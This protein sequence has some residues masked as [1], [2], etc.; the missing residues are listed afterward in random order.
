MDN[1]K[2]TLE[3]KNIKKQFPGVV[4][5]DNVDFKLKHGEIH[6]L[7]GENGAGKST[8]IKILCGVYTKD[9]GEIY[10]DGK[11]IKISDVTTA[12]RFGITFVPQ[13]I[14]LMNGLNVSENIYMG[15]YPSR[16]GF[17]KWGEL[18]KKTD[19]LKN[20]FGGAIK[21]LVNSTLAEDLTIANKQ[22]LEILK[23]LAIDTKILCLDE[24][25]SSLTKDETDRLFK[26]LKQLKESGISIIY[27]SHRMEEI[28][29]IADTVTVFKDG[30]FIK[31]S[32]IKSTSI[33][34]VINSMVGRDLNLLVK[35]DRTKNISDESVL[36]VSNLSIKDKFNNINFNLKKGEILGWF[37]LI[38]SGRSEVVQALFG[39][40]KASGTV[41]IF[42]KELEINSP[43]KAILNKLGLAPEDRHSQG[44]VL[45]L[46]V[47]NNINLPIFDRIS[48]LGFVNNQKAK[49]NSLKFIKDLNIKTP[50][51]NTIV[52]SLSGGNKQKVSIGKWLNANSEILIFDEPTKGID[53]GSKNEIYKLIRILADA[54]KSI[55]FI[56]S[57]LP[58]IINLSD[59]IVVF[60]DGKITK[61]LK[62]EA[63]LNEHDVFK[64]AISG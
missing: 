36:E 17:I 38:G 7:V 27:V 44:L 62:N 28:F 2:Y 46:D 29:Q 50:S 33:T 61:E 57:E 22:I 51:I 58:E 24:P 31:T 52:D 37:G 49:Q 16:F 3:A 45:T 21:G 12:R 35:L 14:E 53:V 30:K 48:R 39:I 8:L 5:L 23:V 41:K 60:K 20:M 26:L 64:Y 25:T 11:N 1:E 10:M 32:D 54:G 18:N 6:A 34:D 63:S 4:A 19:D 55:I 43:K 15:K 40:D 13:E 47:N 42:G 59:R 9:S 56:S